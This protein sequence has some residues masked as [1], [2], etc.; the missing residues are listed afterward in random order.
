MTLLLCPPNSLS[1]IDSVSLGRARDSEKVNSEWPS[2]LGQSGIW[3]KILWFKELPCSEI[4]L[5][6]T[7][8]GGR[9]DHLCQEFCSLAS[10]LHSW[11]Q[12]SWLNIMDAFL[13]CGQRIKTETWCCH[14]WFCGGV[15][16]QR[17]L[18]TTQTLSCPAGVRFKGCCL[19]R[20]WLRHPAKVCLKCS[21]PKTQWGVSG[22]QHRII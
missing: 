1:C 16:R 14:H 9:R 3:A 20:H 8:K 5:G 15:G 7:S 6:P 11:P 21:P 10:G 13:F 2:R 12:R 18:I 19:D 22:Q 17:K 4:S